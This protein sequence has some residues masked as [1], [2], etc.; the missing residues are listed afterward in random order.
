MD[1]NKCPSCGANLSITSRSKSVTCPYCGQTFNNHKGN[2]SERYATLLTISAIIS[3]L[4][5]FITFSLLYPAIFFA[6]VTIICG[7]IAWIKSKSKMA[8]VSIIV[9]LLFIVYLV[10]EVVVSIKNGG[11]NS[12]YLQY[13]LSTIENME[14]FS[15]PSEDSIVQA[16]KEVD[17]ITRVMTATTYHDP[18]NGLAK[19]DGYYSDIF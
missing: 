8:L 4:L 3:L 10:S 5:V 19:E 15:T 11:V 18:N 17:G 1:G 16:L 9:L 12:P 14:N 2:K 13:D 7:I 6:I